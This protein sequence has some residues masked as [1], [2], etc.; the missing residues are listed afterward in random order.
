MEKLFL[1]AMLAIVLSI[2]PSTAWAQKNCASQQCCKEATT[3]EVKAYTPEEI[4][5][6]GAS[7]VGQTVEV[8]GK[9]S[10]VCQQSWRKCFV[11]GEDQSKTIQV[12]AGGDIEKFGADLVKQ[13]IN[14]KGVVKEYRVPREAIEKQEA[15]AK[16]EME[17]EDCTDMKNC[18]HAMSN[19]QG[20]KQW[21]DEH[22]TDYYP[23]YYVEGVHY[24]VVK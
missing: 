17:K 6:N 2:A 21:M 24:D 22:H 16:A 14:A 19:A 23:I 20:M 12:L 5:K 9:V 13:R 18:E 1:S 3:S 15:A 4:M 11:T 8:R 10:H 7:L